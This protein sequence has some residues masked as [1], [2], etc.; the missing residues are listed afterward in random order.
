MT[1]KSD[2]EAVLEQWIQGIENLGAEFPSELFALD[3]D[4]VNWGVGEGERYVG[5]ETYEAHIKQSAQV[6]TE[7]DVSVKE[8]QVR[9][10]HSGDVAWFNQVRD[11]RGTLEDTQEVRLEGVRVTGVL[12]KRDGRWVIVHFH[13]SLGTQDRLPEPDNN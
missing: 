11:Y 2:V 5:F 7:T 4:L 10:S 9:V 3:D 13:H 1:M 8:L 6:L 12:E